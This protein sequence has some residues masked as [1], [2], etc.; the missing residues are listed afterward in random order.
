MAEAVQVLGVAAIKL[1]V[2]EGSALALLGY[3]ENGAFI[4]EEG[5]Y[6]EVP[7]DQNGGDSGPPIEKVYM[8]E[9]ARV[10]IELSKWDATVAA[11]VKNRNKGTTEGTPAAA[12]TLVFAGGYFYRLL[13]HSTTLPRNYLCAVPDQ[14]YEINVGTKYSRLVFEFTCYKHPV[15]GVLR[16]AVTT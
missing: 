10:R 4:T 11:L 12:G 6:Q 16:N 9:T 2:G 13:I 7:G 8:G 5:H 1:D 3:T 15:S 14:P